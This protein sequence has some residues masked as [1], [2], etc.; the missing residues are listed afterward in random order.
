MASS[1][2]LMVFH[3]HVIGFLRR[4]TPLY[5]LPCDL[6]WKVGLFKLRAMSVSTMTP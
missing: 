6:I 5:G 1:L 3:F 4:V 2:V